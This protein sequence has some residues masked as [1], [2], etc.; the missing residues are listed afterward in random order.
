MQQNRASTSRVQSMIISGRDRQNN[1]IHMREVFLN[2]V[3]KG[4]FF[5]LHQIGIED[6]RIRAFFLQQ[7]IWKTA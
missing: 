6:N 7:V 1:T 4:E 5:C 3:E 2:M